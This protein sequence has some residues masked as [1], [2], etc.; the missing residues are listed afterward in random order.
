MICII[1]LIDLSEEPYVNIFHLKWQTKHVFG[2][3]YDQLKLE[4]D[5]SSNSNQ[6]L[7]N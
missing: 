1:Y 6:K 2:L 3:N 5:F 7:L 4:E